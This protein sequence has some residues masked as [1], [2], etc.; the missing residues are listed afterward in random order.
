MKS[1]T[2][3]SYCL[4]IATEMNIV[5]TSHSFYVN[6]ESLFSEIGDESDKNKIGLA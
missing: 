5:Q 4:F 6:N 3:C 1:N 2:H